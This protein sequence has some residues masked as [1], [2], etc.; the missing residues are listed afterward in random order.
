[1]NSVAPCSPGQRA[2]PR[3]RGPASTRNSWMAPSKVWVAGRGRSVGSSS[4]LDPGERRPAS[5]PGRRPSPAPV[6]VR[7]LPG[8]EVAVADGQ[9][10]AARPPCRGSARRGRAAAGRPTS[11]RRRCGACTAAAR[12]RR[13]RAATSSA[14]SS[15]PGGQVERAGQLGDQPARAASC[16]SAG[17]SARSTTASG[18]GTGD[19]ARHH[20]RPSASHG[21]AGAQGLVPGDQRRPTAR[22][23]ASGS[24]APRSRTATGTCTPRRRGRT[25]P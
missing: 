3:R 16:A 10:R 8:R 21:E 17:A 11:R 15:G 6:S 24:S 7:A 2:E 4:G 12:G 25:A 19:R 1:M 18:T 13:R 14:R 23:R 22:P 20:G 5:S 9:R